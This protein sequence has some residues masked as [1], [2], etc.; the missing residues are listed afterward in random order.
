MNSQQQEALLYLRRL[1]ETPESDP[2]EIAGSYVTV[3][4]EQLLAFAAQSYKRDGIG[5]IE[6]DLRGID[7]RTATGTAPIA[8]Y[9]AD[10]GS[11]EWPPN[12]AA[13]L[14]DY[15]PAREAVVLLFQDRAVAQIFVLG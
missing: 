9:P 15:D 10:A 13:I 3:I 14:N 5:V 12:L 6:I 4:S 1:L 11:D 8:Y 2:T 7:L